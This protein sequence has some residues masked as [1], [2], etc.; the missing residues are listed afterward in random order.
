MISTAS[1]RSMSTLAAPAS[2]NQG[3]A[4][5]S[6]SIKSIKSVEYGAQDL[7]APK[8]DPSPR[9]PCCPMVTL[10]P[11]MHSTVRLCC[12]QNYKVGQH[13]SNAMIGKFG[14]PQSPPYKEEKKPGGVHAKLVTCLTAI[15]CRDEKRD[16]WWWNVCFKKKRK[17]GVAPVSVIGGPMNIANKP[18]WVK[19]QEEGPPRPSFLTR[20]FK[21]VCCRCCAKPQDPED[22]IKKQGCCGRC[23][24]CCYT[25]FKKLFGPCY[26]G[27]CDKYLCMCCKKAADKAAETNAAAAAL[28]AVSKWGAVAEAK[29]DPKK[30]GSMDPVTEKPKLDPSLVE[31]N[32]LIRAAIPILPIPLAWLCL[33]ANTVMP[34]SGTL[35]SG[36][37]CLCLGK[38][39]FSIYDRPEG[40]LGS[41]CLNII[42]AI[43]QVFTVIF[44]L[45]G[46]GWSLWWGVIMVRVARKHKKLRLRALEETS[47]SQTA[48]STK[49]ENS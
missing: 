16:R 43:F 15:G 20:F 21:R 17:K 22:G 10:P 26:C 7:S 5:S 13:P 24:S 48:T 28:D 9:L 30:R 45:V 25:W 32:S 2:R 44:C 12:P 14:I 27:C 23:G 4:K 18:S 40:R 46:W 47:G 35:S 49:D 3:S 37:F 29:G 8:P 39:R 19:A 38:S 36:I 33:L 42:V 31:H 11:F 6:K 1:L 41:F 34:G